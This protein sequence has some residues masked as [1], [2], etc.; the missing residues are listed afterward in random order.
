VRYFTG[1]QGWT[2]EYT[3]TEIRTRQAVA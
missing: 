3:G 2:P 1:T